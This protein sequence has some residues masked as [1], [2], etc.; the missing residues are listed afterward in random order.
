MMGAGEGI[1]MVGEERVAT[2]AT[3]D[4]VG[5][6]EITGVRKPEGAAELLLNSCITIPHANSNKS[7]R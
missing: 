3:C 6:R 2:P 7:A 4:D 5:V 1:V